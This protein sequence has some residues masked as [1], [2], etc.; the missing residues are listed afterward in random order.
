MSK[1]VIWVLMED[2]GCVLFHGNPNPNCPPYHGGEIS[3]LLYGERLVWG[4]KK[5]EV[6]KQFDKKAWKK[7]FPLCK[8]KAKRI[9][10]GYEPYK[11]SEV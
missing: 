10:I 5:W 8:I 2:N 4:Y 6:E 9:T 7:R 3:S 11:K 1:R